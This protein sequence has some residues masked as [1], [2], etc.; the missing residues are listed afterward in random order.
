MKVLVVAAHP[1]DE[2][3]GC[4]GT[5]AK[6]TA[7][8]DSVRVLTLTDGVGARVATDP[9]KA[10]RLIA[11]R[12]ER[13]AAANAA[14]SLLGATYASC[15]FPD[16]GMDTVPLLT[17]VQMIEA[18][19][20]DAEIIYTNHGGDLNVDHR[21]THQAVL[22][23]CRPLPGSKVKQIY[24][25]EVA[26]STEWASQAEQAFAPNH[27]VDISATLDRKMDALSFYD[28]EMHAFPHPR[29]YEAVKT[30]ARWRGA[31]VGLEAAEAFMTLRRIV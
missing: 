19:I 2:V 27:F 24:A 14:A 29:S 25:F 20:G 12:K 5:I 6:H 18:E 1:D 31:T 15:D 28:E 23:A 30:L 8:G 9:G 21:I 22:T 17:V 3:L 4:G 11:D 13:Y 7:A 26:S 16:N 10:M